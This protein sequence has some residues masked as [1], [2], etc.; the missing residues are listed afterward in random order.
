[1]I[2]V[3][4]LRSLLRTA[5]GRVAATA[6]GVALAVS[7]AAVLGVFIISAAEKMTRQAVANVPVDWQVEIAAGV[8]SKTVEHALG[9]AAAVKA[10]RAVDYAK[11]EGFSATTG[12]T[13]QV[14]GSGQVI[15]IASDY[16][17]TFPHQVELLSGTHEGPVLFSQTAAN[18]HVAVG[19]AITI[20]RPG[21]PPASVTVAGVAAIPNVDSMF[22]AVG[23]PPGLAPQSPPDNILILPATAWDS[24]FGAQ[25]AERPDAVHMQLHVLLD[26]ARLPSDPVAAYAAVKA[27]ANNFAARVAG[28][29]A[30][31]D[32]LAARLDG[33]RGDALYAKVV[34]LFLGAPGVVLAILV[35]VA[36]AGAGR[37]RRLREQALLRIRGATLLEALGGCTAEA[38]VIGLLGVL[39]GLLLT[40]AGVAA[41]GAKAGS[42]SAVAW[43][44]L[45]ALA[46][47]G[48]AIAAILVPAARDAR[49]VTVASARGATEVRTRPLWERL[50][51]AVAMLVLAAG[52]FWQTSGAGYEIVLASEGVAQ[53]SVHYEAFLAPLALWV[54]LGLLWVRIARAGFTAG[55]P[56]RRYA[57]SLTSGD[58]GSIVGASLARQASRLAAGAGLVALATGFA[59]STAIFNMTYDGQA[60]VDAELTNGA[61]V[62]ITGSAD[63]PAGAKL[64]QIRATPGVA[65]AQPMMHRYAYVGTDLQDLYGIAPRAIG[66]ATTMAD[67]YFAN[68]D[69]RGALA[70]LAATRD[71][72]LVSEETVQDFQLQPGDRV[73]LR[74]QSAA[75]HQYHVVPFTFI[76]V[77]REFPTAPKDSFLVA[78]DHYVAEMTAADAHEVVLVRTSDPSLGARLKS[79]LASDPALKVTVVGEVRSLIS[80]SLTAVSLAAMSKLELAFGLLLVAAAAGLVLGLGFAERNRTYVILKAL[81]ASPQQLGAFLR[82]EALLVTA[83]GLIFGMITGFGVA[84]VLVSMLAGVFD[85]PPETIAVPLGYLAVAVI[86][87]GAVAA[88]VVFAFGRAH[89][90]MSPAALKPE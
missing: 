20:I 40:W 71:G 51:V 75:D 52:V 85:P 7:L 11:V 9:E 72:V 84:W 34:F 45:A 5:S 60:R 73:N 41:I 86:G 68:R 54:G 6:G 81:G 12:D 31:A 21:L 4:W 37:P 46:G 24:L 14:T 29:A 78:N 76:G 22:Q 50:W 57:L 61:D 1:M 36:I 39:G 65:A 56:I 89:V 69:A 87:T 70:K 59:V 79:Q 44:S 80:S 66:T 38:I 53:T 49:N 15:G 30:I 42:P 17:A 62:N 32:N 58:L 26:H 33:V 23:A 8:S 18:L 28:I 64:A 25:R 90:G 47:L 35:T 55:G 77:V 43:I 19:D 74:L 88:A 67:A 48:L 82:S 63:H 13:Q 16:L 3:Y 83:T 27:M 10:V 2:A